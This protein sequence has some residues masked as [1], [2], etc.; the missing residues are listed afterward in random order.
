MRGKQSEL[1]PIKAD[2]GLIPACAGKTG[3]NDRFTELVW[4]HPRVCGENLAAMKRLFPKAGSSPRVRGK[5]RAWLYGIIT[6]R[7]IPACAGKTLFRG[8]QSQP[9]PAHPRVCGEN[10]SIA[11][12]QYL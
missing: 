10:V 7:L 6:A 11:F 2:F 1:V 3:L 9:D 12:Q 8:N 4:A 5:L